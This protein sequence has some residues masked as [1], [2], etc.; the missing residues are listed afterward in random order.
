MQE[1]LTTRR[2]HIKLVGHKQRQ[3]GL[4]ISSQ[5][6]AVGSTYTVKLDTPVEYRTQLC[7]QITVTRREI[8]SVD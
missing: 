6:R 4:V 8:L 2:V 1:N 3:P 7:Q 5:V